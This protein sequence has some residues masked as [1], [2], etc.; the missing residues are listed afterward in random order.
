MELAFVMLLV[1]CG[2][3]LIVYAG[4]AQRIPAKKP[5]PD[6]PSDTPRDGDNAGAGNGD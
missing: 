1:V 2:V 5:E 4:L 6:Q 3:G